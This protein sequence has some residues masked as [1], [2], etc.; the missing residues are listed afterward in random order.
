ML[1]Y[2]LRHGETAWNVERRIQGVSDTPLNEVGRAQSQ[3]L[4]TPLQ[5]RPFTALYT[6]PLV[7]AR[8]TADVLA[9][10][11]RLEVREDPRL[12]ELDQGELEGMNFDQIEER[13]NGFLDTWRTAPAD[14]QMPGGE[15][16]HQLQA[17]AWAAVEEI[18]AAH[19]E[20]M[21]I[22]VSHNLAISTLLCRIMEMDL[23][24]IRR[25]R[26]HNA[27]INL[28]EHNPERGWSVLTMNAVSHLDGQLSSDLKPYL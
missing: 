28:V 10:A 6:S 5:G 27:A 19:P 7:R 3:A 21:V 1:L 18:Q 15:N 11:L 20:E 17:R 26:Q 9:A 12:A 14:I 24:G 23:N 16:L 4:I 2:L 13:F 22:A 8:Q 25:I